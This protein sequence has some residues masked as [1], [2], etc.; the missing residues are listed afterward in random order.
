VRGGTIPG[1]HDV[2]FAGEDE[3]LTLSHMAYS[4]KVFAKGALSAAAFLAGKPAGY[5][6]MMDVIGDELA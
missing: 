2:I 4:R 6:T 5:Y 1:D 3:V